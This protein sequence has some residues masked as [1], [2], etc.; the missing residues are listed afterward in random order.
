MRGMTVTAEVRRPGSALAQS[1]VPCTG[2]V[3]EREVMLVGS[4]RLVHN[5][6]QIAFAIW[7]GRPRT[8]LHRLSALMRRVA[9]LA[10]T[11]IGADP[12]HHRRRLP[13]ARWSSGAAP[14]TPPGA[15]DTPRPACTPPGPQ[16]RAPLD[17]GTSPARTGKVKALHSRTCSH[18]PGS[19]RYSWH[20]SRSYNRSRSPHASPWKPTRCRF[21]D[22]NSRNRTPSADLAAPAPWSCRT[23]FVSIPGLSLPNV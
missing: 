20:P 5:C 17:D 15:F 16:P 23:P 19:R 18:C 14:A 2:C 9:I 3:R 4:G 10:A 22:R 8:R 6:A 11:E 13:P 12:R 1:S 21:P 7:S